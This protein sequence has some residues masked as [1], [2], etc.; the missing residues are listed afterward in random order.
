MGSE[1][2]RVQALLP[3]FERL[4][5]GVHVRVQ[6]IP[7][8][9]AHEKLLTAHVGGTLPDVFQLGNTWLPEFVA[10]KALAPLDDV[11]SRDEKADI[12]PGILAANTLNTHL[13]G[14]P[15]YVDTRLLFYRSDLLQH[16]GV[17]HA[18]QTWSEWLVALRALKAY[19]GH[20]PLL[21]PF[22]EWQT[23]IALSLQQQ[24]ALLRDDARYGDFTQPAFRTALTFYLQLFREGLAEVGGELRMGNLYQAFADGRL[25]M[26]VSGPWNIGEI[27]RKMPPSLQDAWTTSP[28][29][30]PD[31]ALYPGIS[32]AGGASLAMRAD[33]AH[34]ATARALL[35]YL[36]QPAQQLRFYLAT[37][38]LPVRMSAWTEGGLRTVPRVEAFWQQLQHV[39]GVPAVPEWERIATLIMRHA[40]RAARGLESEDAALE[41][42]NVET[43]ALLTKRRWMMDKTPP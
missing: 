14:L 16:A 11:L 25:A 34:P 37:G 40:E 13:Y 4:H 43:N 30:V 19:S 18:P 21:L 15:W 32:I 23:L 33:T 38:D 27:E 36:M 8:S 10:I 41:A 42:I 2:E 1:G 28:L 39:R 35:A 7:W 20:A 26:L 3:E 22:S 31:G 6:Q 12:F 17:A 29:P 24:A 9:A 5:P